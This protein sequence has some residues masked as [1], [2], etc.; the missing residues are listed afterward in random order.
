[1]HSNNLSA[2]QGTSPE[3]TYPAGIIVPIECSLVSEEEIEFPIKLTIFG[4]KKP[5]GITTSRFLL[6]FTPAHSSTGV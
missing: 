5:A 6:R 2:S 3:K 1:L 4:L